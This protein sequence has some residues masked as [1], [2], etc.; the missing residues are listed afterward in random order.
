MSIKKGDEF[1]P[2]EVN[3]V[4]KAIV[5][6]GHEMMSDM[7]HYFLN[8]DATAYSTAPDVRLNQLHALM[9]TAGLMMDTI[10]LSLLAFF[11]VFGSAPT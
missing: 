9:I 6:R 5:D 2:L 7:N 3:G 11:T 8:P 10:V 1:Y 4:K